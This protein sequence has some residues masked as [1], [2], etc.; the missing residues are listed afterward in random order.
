MS[1]I[2]FARS[3]KPC[4][5]KSCQNARRFFFAAKRSAS[6][7]SIDAH[8][9]PSRE[10]HARIAKRHGISWF[11]TTGL[12]QHV[13]LREVKIREFDLIAVGKNN[14]AHEHVLEFAHIPRP[15]MNEQAVKSGERNIFGPSIRD[16][17]LLLQKIAR[18]QQ[19]IAG[20]FAQ[21]WKRECRVRSVGRTNPHGIFPSVASG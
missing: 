17:S 12:P 13:R 1:S 16:R 14:G 4:L 5:R 8:A 20:T 6:D 21:R 7:I 15:R 18:E 10:S 3:S 9:E 11:G 2:I 19:D